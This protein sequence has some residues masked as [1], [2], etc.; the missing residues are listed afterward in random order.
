MRPAHRAENTCDKPPIPA[1]AA[2]A[3]AA[4]PIYLSTRLHRLAYEN[5]VSDAYLVL[6]K[7]RSASLRISSW[8]LFVGLFIAT[9][10]T[11]S[12]ER[13]FVAPRQARFHASASAAPIQ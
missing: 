10:Y 9:D 11:T 1:T 12:L 7:T 6:S 13:V 4:L 5:W 2:R 8:E 3:A